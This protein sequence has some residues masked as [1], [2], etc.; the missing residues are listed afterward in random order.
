MIK[1]LYKT[2]QLFV[3]VA[4]IFNLRTGWMKQLR[5]KQCNIMLHEGREFNIDE[6]DDG[7]LIRGGYEKKYIRYLRGVMKLDWVVLDVGANIGYFTVFFGLHCSKVFAI[8][9]YR[10]NIKL[11]KKNTVNLPVEIIEAVA[12]DITGSLHLYVPERKTDCS[13]KES[14]ERKEKILVSSYRLDDLIKEKIDFIKIDVQGADTEVLLGAK[15]L[16]EKFRPMLM[17]EYENPPPTL[18]ETLRIYDYRFYSITKG[19]KLV[20]ENYLNFQPDRTVQNLIAMHLS[21]KRNVTKI[22]FTGKVFQ[23]LTA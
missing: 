2:L 7:Y 21:D 5:N 14:S 17:I 8:E 13:I 11:L 3:P 20:A 4:K 6:N 18:L 23:R 12:S 22:N 15:E 9:P 19:G 10:E 16:I 1:I